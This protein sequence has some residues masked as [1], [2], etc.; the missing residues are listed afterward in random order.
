[1]HSFPSLPA[2][3]PSFY[4]AHSLAIIT[5]E[6]L[7]D[8]TTYLVGAECADTML[9][10]QDFLNPSCL[11]LLVSKGLG[12]A[13]VGGSVIRKC[14][15]VCF[16]CVCVCPLSQTFI[17]NNATLIFS[18]WL[19]LLPSPC[20]PCLNSRNNIIVKIIIVFFFVLVFTSSHLSLLI[21]MPNPAVS[22]ARSQIAT[23]FENCW[24]R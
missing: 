17:W 15:C 4:F 14:F 16:A 9:V 12:I 24:I 22:P 18:P 13:I 8:A 23:N 5:M 6:Y 21:L 10:E 7:H 19:G 1:M 3:P 2:L 20:P 11:K